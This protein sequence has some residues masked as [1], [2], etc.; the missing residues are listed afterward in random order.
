VGFWVLASQKEIPLP[1][2]YLRICG[3]FPKIP[4]SPSLTISM[5]KQSYTAR[6]QFKK[7]VPKKKP[8]VLIKNL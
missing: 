5:V 1:L 6:E 2:A 3:G 4:S 7:L 8:I